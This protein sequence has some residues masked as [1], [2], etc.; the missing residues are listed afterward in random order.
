MA[1]VPDEALVFPKTQNHFPF[2][3]A[4][5]L[6]RVGVRMCVL[7]LSLSDAHVWAAYIGGEPPSLCPVCGTPNYYSTGTKGLGY[8]EGNH[9]EAIPI[10]TA[11]SDFG[12]TLELNLTYNSYNAD[13]SHATL[14]TGL[15][16]GWTHSYNAF[17]F[18][19]VAN[20]FRMDGDGRTEKF[21]AGPQN[22]FTSDTGYFETL[23]NNP[24]GSFTLVTKDRTIYQYAAVPNSPI[25]VGGP[26]YQLQSVI[27]R[28]HNTNKLTYTA[29]NLTRVTDTF[30]RFM[31]FSYNSQKLLTQV[32]DPLGR[33][34]TF[35]Y[36]ST[37]RRLSKVTD[38]AGK[39][40]VYSYNTLNQ[41]V[42]KT[43]PEG[44][45][46]TYQYQN[47]LPVGAKDSASAA[48][49]SLSNTSKWATAFND[50]ATTQKRVYVPST[51]QLTD[52]RS[53]VWR[54]QYDA[55]GYPTNVIAPDGSRTRYTYDPGTLGLATMTDPNGNT[56]SYQY[57]SKGNRTAVIDALGHVT[58]FTYEPVF[59]RKTSMTDPNSR[60]TLYAYD[61]AGNQIRETDPLGRTREWIYDSHGNV[62]AEK[63]KRGNITTYVYNQLGLRTNMIDAFGASTRY[64]YDAI[65]NL[66]SRTDANG[67]TTAYAYDPLDR[68]IRTVDALGQTNRTTYDSDGHVSMVTDRLGRATRYEYDH[69][70]R[71]TNTVDAL[72]QTLRSTYD[73]NNNL[74]T[75]TDK[76][77]T[78]TTNAYDSRNRIIRTS[79]PLGVVRTN[80][81]DPANNLISS[82]DANGHTT[83]FGYDALN[84]QVAMTNA[85]GYVTQWEYESTGCPV[86]SGAEIGS[87]LV[88]RV[89]D[90][91]GK[92]T[93]FKYD[94][95]NRLVKTIRKEG[96]IADSIDASDAVSEYTYDANGNVLSNREPDG[97]AVSYTY[98]ALNRQTSIINS[99]GDATTSFYDGVGNLLF[100]VAPNGRATTNAYDALDR[101]TEAS[102]SAGLVTRNSYDPVGNRLTTTDGNNNTTQSVYDALNRMTRSIDPLGGTNS[103]AYDPNGNTIQT[104]DREGH[105][106]TFVYDVRNRRTQSVDALL[107]STV[108]Q[109]DPVGNL[110]SVTD[111]NGHATSY[112][113]DAL[114]RRV[115]E[116][117]PDPN[118]NSRTFTYDAVNRTS[119]TDQKGLVTTYTYNDLYFLTQRTYPISPADHF[120]YD[121]SG[122]MLS[123]EKDG[124]VVTFT[125]DAA[126]RL[127]HTQQG[128]QGI[129]YA[130]D[131]PG[132]TRT[133]MY[134]SGRLVVEATDARNRLITINDAGSPPPIVQYTYDLGN[135]VGSRIYRNGVVATYAYDANNWLRSV[136]HS[137]GPT[138]IA[139]FGYDYDREGNKRFEENRHLPSQS[140]TY[141]YDAVYR[142][143][144][145]ESGALSGGAI[146]APV[147]DRVWDLDPV[148]NWNSVLNNAVPEIRTH[149]AAN[150]ILTVNAAAL[151]HDHDGNLQSDPAYAYAYDEENRLIQITRLADSV[152]V[153]QYWYDALGRR[154]QSMVNP[155]GSPSTTRY[156]YDDSRVLEEQDTLGSPLATYVYGNY[157]DEILMMNRAGQTYFYHQ[158]ALWSVEAVT[159]A[160]GGAVERYAYDAY[161]QPDISDGAGLPVP[162]NSWGVPHSAIGNPYM[163][164][165]RQFDEERGLYFYRARFHDPRLGRFLQRDPL[166]PQ[167]GLNLYEYAASRPGFFADPTGLEVTCV[168]PISLELTV[169]GGVAVTVQYCEDE[170]DNWA[171]VWV[172]SPRVGFAIGI[173]AGFGGAA[174]CLKDWIEGTTFDLTASV[175][176]A[177]GGVDYQQEK[178]KF[179]GHGGV[180]Y[181][182]S[183]IGISAGLNP[184]QVIK[185]NLCH[186]CPC[187]EK[188]C[189][190][191]REARM[192]ERLEEL[193][194]DKADIE[195]RIELDAVARYY[196]DRRNMSPD[197]VRFVTRNFGVDSPG[198]LDQ[199]KVP[200][201]FLGRY[202]G[203]GPLPAKTRCDYVRRSNDL[204]SQ[205]RDMSKLLNLGRQEPTQTHP[206][207]RLPS[208]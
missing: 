197:E 40:T 13:G 174:G 127:V 84:R 90:G 194:R 164:T 185:G 169:G 118:P 82:T 152:T 129:D 180:G 167:D 99:A 109:Y 177:S 98:D 114:N 105:L 161:G 12:P 35:S 193:K 101:L 71:R 203:P 80:N 108:Y 131:I 159:D 136:E 61:A 189:A 55:N 135:R 64:T 16:F 151:A 21:Q 10:L 97:N 154:I 121:L 158:N 102:D 18:R 30:G 132:R 117:Y 11:R 46:F 137:I 14:N 110:I 207:L 69:R 119:R 205:I 148:G 153:G 200:G 92:V 43:D 146:P 85:L 95:L 7:L 58:S 45:T 57:D 125:Y 17:L 4:N 166:D 126:D 86:C 25:L 113:Y 208:R 120:T 51:T 93:Y 65:G 54:Y 100:S 130:H 81:Y 155:D 60:T 186:A 49:L 206:L 171:W 19:Q 115:I 139:G 59:N 38:P 192:R 26:V 149:N 202:S 15:G 1:L 183:K 179:G 73:P 142:L 24:D 76:R 56:T 104:T 37:G 181:G 94:A 28:N 201:L 116:V 140:E 83:R 204:E 33:A 147:T 22:S 156:F 27:D 134:P 48:L 168:T 190:R 128:A 20:V 199:L 3:K 75:T 50:L 29:G 187:E 34:T 196:W 5:L 62:L 111:P 165:G 143:T 172:P 122:R 88:T 42:T 103:V 78:T 77:G 145:F 178:T 163:F 74:L 175:R 41:I 124:W 67:H 138:R 173:G 112:A 47:N 89:T 184:T 107:H 70:G 106:T 23:T 36:D 182:P 68:L 123:A 53:N 2:M 32:I 91:N 8:T 170:C 52:G 150:E 144:R 195:R 87:S 39:S 72:N 31:Q 44:R 66:L 198:S 133:I 141:A 79:D 6:V 63:D 191:Q 176:I 9:R 162:G 188:I 96:D 157:V 160:A